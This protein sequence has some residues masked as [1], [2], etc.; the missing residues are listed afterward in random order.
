M[1]INSSIGLL[2]HELV[3]LLLTAVVV[4]IYWRK[5]RDYRLIIA[6]LIFGVLI[7]VDHW[8]D[9][10]H[11]FGFRFDLVKFFNVGSYIVPGG[12]IFVLLHGWEYLPIFYLLGKYLE[13][14]WNST[15]LG[16]VIFLCY[17]LHLV[18]DHFS[19]VHHP[20]GYSLIFRLLNRFSQ[21]SFDAAQ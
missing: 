21:T 18:W 9:F 5:H 17:L 12:S 19:F 1:N 15:G 13:R 2:G 3:H 10:W 4:I 7:D 14:K 16:K 11:F 8:F 20:L 6:A